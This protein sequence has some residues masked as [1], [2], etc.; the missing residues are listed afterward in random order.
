MAVSAYQTRRAHHR[1]EERHRRIAGCALFEGVAVQTGLSRSLGDSARAVT[2]PASPRGMTKHECR[3]E[4]ITTGEIRAPFRTTAVLFVFA[5]ASWIRS[6]HRDE[7]RLTRKDNPS[8]M[9]CV[10][11]RTISAAT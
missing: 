10:L 5:E 7:F 1:R 6:I 3:V 11:R 9:R 2:A 4:L 8:R